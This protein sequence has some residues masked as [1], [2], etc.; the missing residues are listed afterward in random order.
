M[1]RNMRGIDTPFDTALPR[2]EAATGTRVNA[3]TTERLLLG[4]L[5]RGTR[6]S[7]RIQRCE[8]EEWLISLGVPLGNQ[9]SELEF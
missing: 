5:Q 7:Q 8:E 9:F 3:I 6:P 2:N 1:L 4:A